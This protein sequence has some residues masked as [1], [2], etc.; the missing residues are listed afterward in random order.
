MKRKK[1]LLFKRSISILVVMTILTTGISLDGIIVSA[2][3]D[4]DYV[5]N[6]K[7]EELAQMS[8]AE[9][10]VYLKELEDSGYEFKELKSERTLN[11]TTYELTDGIKKL[12]EYPA[13]LDLKMKMVN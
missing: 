3:E 6:S 5:M 4:E 9:F 13:M 11:S 12:V 2:K 8:D 10:D 1:L 7:T